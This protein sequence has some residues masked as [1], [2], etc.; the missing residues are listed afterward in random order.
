MTRTALLASLAA[1]VLVQGVSV[2]GQ[3]N[4]TPMTP[5]GEPDL[6]GTWTAEAEL[7]VPFERPR[8]YGTRQVLSDAEFKQRETQSE[9]QLQ[10]DNSD[11]DLETADRSTAGQVGSATSPPPHWL[12]RR[13]ISRRTSLVIDPPDGRVP[14]L[15]REAQARQTRAPL[16]GDNGAD[17]PQDLSLWVRCIGRGMPSAIFPTVYNANVQIVQAPGVVALTYEMIHDTRIIRTDGSPHVGSGVRGYFGDSRGHW[18]GDTLVVDVTNVSDKNNYRGSRDTL[19]LVERFKRA[20]NGLRYEVT[21]EDAQTWTAPWTAALELEPQPDGMFEYA[22]HE[23][24]NSMRNIL[25]GARAA[26]RRTDGRTLR[27][28]KSGPAFV[29]SIPCATLPARLRYRRW[30]L[31]WASVGLRVSSPRPR[32]SWHRWRCALASRNS[33]PPALPS[34]HHLLIAPHS[35]ATA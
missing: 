22:C 25:S 4:K 21:A 12:E 10:S 7:S 1:F 14:P 23:G 11:F 19:R 15:T 16:S 33:R 30:K 29:P 24:N 35:I 34:S 2:V 8:E 31:P 26:D 6:Q 3:G 13:K 20:G 32:V 18:E 9:R 28:S 17:R 27:R 5:W